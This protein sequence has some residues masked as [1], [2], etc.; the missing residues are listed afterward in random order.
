MKV[1][2]LHV[3]PLGLMASPQS[4][5]VAGH[6]LTGPGERQ[7]TWKVLDPERPCGFGL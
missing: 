6:S 4:E 3:G 1:F 5:G 2:G 7:V